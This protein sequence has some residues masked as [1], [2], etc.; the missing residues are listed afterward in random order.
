MAKRPP[1]V[2]SSSE[3]PDLQIGSPV[4]AV[5]VTGTVAADPN[6]PIPGV[7]EET[8]PDPFAHVGDAFWG[9]GGRY[10]VDGDGKRTPAPVAPEFP[11][12][13]TKP[14]ATNG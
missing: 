5:I 10:V 1:G 2:P 6:S 3:T 8:M 12:L 13:T 9:Q 11:P 14:E 7:L 4:S